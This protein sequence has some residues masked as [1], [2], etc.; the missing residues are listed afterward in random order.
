MDLESGPDSPLQR[1]GQTLREARQNRGLDRTDLAEQLHMGPEQLRALEEADL[2]RLPEMVF[3]IAQSRRVANALGIEIDALL[4]PLKGT[5][6]PR[7]AAPA[8]LVTGGGKPSKRAAQLRP[9]DYTRQPPKASQGSPLP[10]MGTVALLAGLV[11]AGS[12]GWLQLRPLLGQRAATPPQPA[13]VATAPP[14]AATPKPVVKAAP[15]QLTLSSVKG[16]WLEVRSANGQKLFEG[17]FK[18]ERRFELGAGLRVLA[19]RPDLVMAS[20][21]DQPAKALGPI[22]QVIWRTFKP[23][24]VKP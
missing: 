18:G 1:L 12:W 20:L 7:K 22:D 21:G 8:P 23:Q 4:T 13:A 10:W 17:I 5:S 24:S 11:A 9:E 19:G 2:S 14:A 16:S 15:R 6:T 3:V